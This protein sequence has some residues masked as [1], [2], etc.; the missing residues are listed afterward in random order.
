MR[1][2][3]EFLSLV[4]A[5]VLLASGVVSAA[6]PL[7]KKEIDALKQTNSWYTNEPVGG[8][9]AGAGTSGATV[10]PG[11][12]VRAAFLYFIQRGL[13]PNQSAGFV[14]NL[15]AESGVEPD[16]NEKNPVVPGSRGGYGIAQWTA[17]RRTAI[18][19]YAA[20]TG[21]DLKSLQ[22]QLD[23]LWDQELMK[24][25]KTR[26][27]DPLM[28]TTT[29]KQASDI[30]LRKFET[31]KVIID[32]IP[33]QVRELENLRAGLGEKVLELYAAEANT[34]AAG[35]ATAGSASSGA[36][37]CSATPGAAAGFVGFPLQTTKPQIAA[38]NGGCFKDSEQKMCR[39]GHPYAAYDIMIDQNTPVLS[40]LNGTV[41]GRY[42]DRCGGSMLSVYSQ[43]E[44]VTLS[45]LHMGA[46]LA[47][48]DGAT[49]TAGQVIG[50]VGSSAD[51]CGTGAHLHIDA[52]AGNR[53]PG[54]SRLSCPSASA[55]NFEEGD[56][57][58]NLGGGLYTGYKK[59]P[60]AIT[61]P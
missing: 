18:E 45:Y 21:G 29:V 56:A 25:Y 59:L 30:V 51:A 33:Q 49:V 27:L 42:T 15:I 17:G 8:C 44:G 20:S 6:E 36:G 13:T 53:R 52:A 9:G 55:T 4:M 2:F 24:A 10:Q 40:L 47:V 32:N 60:E 1:A 35:T 16:I 23:Y 34:V 61:T 41:Q 57:K 46:N 48:S 26:V 37:G 7:S 11:E 14:G 5:V 19:A 12:N 31:P 43:A 58:I 39:A 3:K 50:Y 22:F 28:Q 38:L 54:C